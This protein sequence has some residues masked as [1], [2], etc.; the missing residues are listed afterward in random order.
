MGPRKEMGLVSPSWSRCRSLLRFRPCS[1]CK[2]SRRKGIEP[3]HEAG[4]HL[5]M[6]RILRGWHGCRRSRDGRASSR[7]DMR[8]PPH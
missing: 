3:Y 4:Y 8:L 5:C 7:L 2:G 6:S 1:P